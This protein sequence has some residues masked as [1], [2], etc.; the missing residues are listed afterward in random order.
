V[1]AADLAMRRAQLQLRLLGF[2][3]LEPRIDC[4]GVGAADDRVDQAFDLPLQELEVRPDGGLACRCRRT[5]S[6][7]LDHELA[8]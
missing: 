6:V 8:G 3:F 4:V 2:K 5:L 1:Q 7:D